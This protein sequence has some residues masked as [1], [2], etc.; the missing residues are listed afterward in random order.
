MYVKSN[1]KIFANELGKLKKHT[2]ITLFPKNVVNFGFFT[3]EM[4]CERAKQDLVIKWSFLMQQ[5]SLYL[6][7]K[8]PGKRVSKNMIQLAYFNYYKG[9]STK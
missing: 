6:T 1:K 8:M 7:T 3:N 2:K 4:E 9:K 5:V